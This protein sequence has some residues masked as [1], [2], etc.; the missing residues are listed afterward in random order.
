M[1]QYF[2]NGF[3]PFFQFGVLFDGIVLVLPM[4]SN[5]QFGNFVHHT[6]AYLHFHPGAVGA[7]HGEVQG[8]IAVTLGVADPIAYTIRLHAVYIG[9]DGIDLPAAIFIANRLIGLKNDANGKQIINLLKGDFLLFHLTP[10]GV[11]AFHAGTD[12]VL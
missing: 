10:N 7:H 8:A 4:R 5:A 12:L 2:A 3:E 6:A 9:D 11:T 1:F